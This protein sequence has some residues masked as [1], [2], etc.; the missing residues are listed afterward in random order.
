MNEHFKSKGCVFLIL[1]TPDNLMEFRHTWKMSPRNCVEAY[2]SNED[3]LR[4]AHD[5]GWIK[6]NPA[7]PI[8]VP[9]VEESESVPFPE[10]HVEIL[11]AGCESYDGDDQRLKAQSLLLLWT[12]LRIGDASTIDREKITKDKDGWNVELRTPKT[13]TEVGRPR[14]TQSIR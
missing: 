3:V 8:A 11:L 1:I 5:F 10:E 4:F 13:G 12:G 14:C 9:K 2:R 6:S 7:K